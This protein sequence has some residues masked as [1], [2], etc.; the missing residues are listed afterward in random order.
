MNHTAVKI[1]VT[2]CDL[3]KD[4]IPFIIAVDKIK[5]ILEDFTKAQK[6]EADKTQKKLDWIFNEVDLLWKQTSDPNLGEIRELF[7]SD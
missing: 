3:V 5:I 4:N 2:C 1:L 7:L 6:A